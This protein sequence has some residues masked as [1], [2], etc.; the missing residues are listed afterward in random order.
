MESQK[1]KKGGRKGTRTMR[2]SLQSQTTTS[3]WF[4][5][6]VAQLEP[7]PIFQFV[8]QPPMTPA[9][10]PDLISKLIWEIGKAAWKQTDPASYS[11]NQLMFELAPYCPPESR[12]V[13]GVGALAS[14]VYGVGQV[15]DRVD[16]AIEHERNR[17]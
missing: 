4:G 11:F 2:P 3:M 5:I 12:W 13:L 10:Q 1:R 9:A 8:P 16:K 14:A 17:R 15:V 7:T 6:P